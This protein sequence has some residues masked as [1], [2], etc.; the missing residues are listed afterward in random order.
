MNTCVLLSASWSAMDRTFCLYHTLLPPWCSCSSLW[1][2]EIMDWLYPPN[3]GSRKR[4]FL[5]WAERDLS[6]LKLSTLGN[7][8]TAME[9]ESMHCWKQSLNTEKWYHHSQQGA[10]ARLQPDDPV[11]PCLQLSKP[12]ANTS[13]NAKT[14][15]WS[16]SIANLIRSTLKQISGPICKG[17]SRL[18]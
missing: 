9:K 13:Y 6:S 5:P 8:V 4:S 2:K 14:P 1:S 17:V 18:G 7:L 3:T 15:W 11:V 12:W 10:T 16:I